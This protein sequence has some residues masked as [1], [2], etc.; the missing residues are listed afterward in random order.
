MTLLS[1]TTDQLLSSSLVL[2]RKHVWRCEHQQTVGAAPIAQPLAPPRAPLRVALVSPALCGRYMSDAAA[3][4]SSC[5]A[6]KTG[7]GKSMLPWW[8][9]RIANRREEE[10]ISLMRCICIAG[11]TGL[12]H[13]HHAT[14]QQKTHAT[15]Q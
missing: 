4:N 13:R 11:M 5:R 6:S 3:G 10:H 12:G 14:V 15:V 7:C 9:Q 8:V 2:P 1:R